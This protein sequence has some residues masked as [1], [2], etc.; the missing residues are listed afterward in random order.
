MIEVLILVL[1]EH[2]QRDKKSNKNLDECCGL[3][4]CFI[5]TFPKRHIGLQAVRIRRP[6]LNPCF[7]GTFPKRYYIIHFFRKYESSLNP[8]FIGTFPKSPVMQMATCHNK[9]VLILVLLE[10]SQ[11]VSGLYNEYGTPICLNPCFIGTFPKS[12]PQRCA[13]RQA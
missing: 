12:R 7:I 2:S 8:C 10:H 5:G 4:P 13:C 3:N 9:A 11:R 6:C 1:L